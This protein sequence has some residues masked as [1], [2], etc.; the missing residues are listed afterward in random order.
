[1]AD[2]DDESRARLTS[3]RRAR[4]L[5]EYALV[6]FIAWWVRLYPRRWSLAG[7]SFVGTF[8][9]LA[10]RHDRRVARANLDLVLGDALS[11]AAKRRVVR[12]TFQRVGRVIVGLL[13]APELAPAEVA[14]L[15]DA[16][17]FWATLR[18][19]ERRGQGAVL[20][21]AHYGDWELLCLAT[22]AAGFPLL[23]VAEPVANDRLERLFVALRTCTG[24][25]T[26]P[27]K[28]AALKLFR[29]L[30]RGERV[31]L[32]CDAN[33]RRGRGGVWVDL[34]GRQVFNGTALAEL[35]LR[36][37]SAVVFAAAHPLPG[38]RC[39]V[40]CRP[41][42]Y[43]RAT[44]DHQA[45]VRRVTQ[46]VVDCHADLLRTSPEPWLWTYKRWKRKPTPDAAGY[47]FYARYARV[48]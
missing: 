15:V 22:A 21:T 3:L 18:D 12:R 46:A 27:P 38:G 14:G 25:R 28:Y 34:C 45:D 29:G 33:G 6:R 2:V 23:V 7:G 31:A 42:L 16:D 19:L 30:R 24:N 43:P 47:P 1:M 32:T 9:Y 48:E 40:E 10:M 8:V 41:P 20:V 13:Y 4:H 36:T 26:V 35:A 11:P 37:G 39:R 5:A 17:P 44:G